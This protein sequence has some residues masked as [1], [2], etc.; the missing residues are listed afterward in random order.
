MNGVLDRASVGT[1]NSTQMKRER[2]TNTTRTTTT[3]RRVR[4]FV[5]A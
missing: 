1:V 3:T 4:A 2:Q 5:H